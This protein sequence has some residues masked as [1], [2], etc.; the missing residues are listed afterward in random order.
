[1]EAFSTGGR[2]HAAGQVRIY[3]SCET[4]ADEDVEV[5]RKKLR[6]W[7]ARFFD[8]PEAR[9]YTDGQIDFFVEEKDHDLL[10]GRHRN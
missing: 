1:M 6:D 4:P 5:T 7:A 3:Q 2:D 10:Q 8:L 9:F